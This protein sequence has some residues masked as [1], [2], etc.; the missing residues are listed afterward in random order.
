M[1]RD[2][3]LYICVAYCFP[4]EPDM[5]GAGERRVSLCAD[6][7]FKTIVTHY[8]VYHSSESCDPGPA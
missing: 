1:A 6:Y 4:E 7:L 2:K 3:L 8:L 5:E